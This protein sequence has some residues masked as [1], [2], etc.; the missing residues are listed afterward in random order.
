MSQAIKTRMTAEEFFRWHVA[1]ERRYELV[2]GAPVLMAGAN[3]RHAQIVSNTMF[4]IRSRLGAGGCRPFTSD[5]AIRIPAGNIRYPDLSV[6]CGR[7]VDDSMHAVEP[8][9]VVEVLSRSPAIF[10]QTEKLEEYRTVPDL[11]HVLVVNSDQP[12]ARLH[13]RTESGWTSV[14]LDTPDAVVALTAIDVAFPLAALHEGLEFRPRPS[15]V[16]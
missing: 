8:R 16:G 13:T 2:D 3:L 14:R 9:V 7:L 15:L 12:E 5:T 6:D 11:M 1:Q 10:D 4:A